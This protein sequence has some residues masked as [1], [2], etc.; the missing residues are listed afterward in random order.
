MSA[1]AYSDVSIILA[2]IPYDACMKSLRYYLE[3]LAIPL[4]FV[5][6]SLSLRVVWY[7]FD[8]PS[9]DVFTDRIGAWIYTYGAPILFIS[10]LAEGMLLVGGYFPGI[11]V[12]TISVITARTPYEAAFSVLVGSAGLFVAHMINYAL[13]RFGWYRILVRFGLSSSVTQA[14]ARLEKRGAVAIFLSYWMP[15]LAALTDTAAGIMH[16]P[17]FRFALWSLAGVLFWDTVAG[18]VMYYLG[19]RAIALAS[20]GGGNAWIVF[21]ALGLWM[22]VLIILDV[23]KKVPPSIAIP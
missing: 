6:M 21:G 10:A 14:R 23:R 22:L 12:I 20:P 11:F 1:N 19:D 4:G 7:V 17:F 3:L 13:G 15:S 18:T 5:V 16:L 9:A 2:T 8:L